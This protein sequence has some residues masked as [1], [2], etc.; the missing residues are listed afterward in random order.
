MVAASSSSPEVTQAWLT[1]I[2]AAFPGMDILCDDLA[3]G[4][5]CHIGPGG[6]GIGVSCRPDR[7]VVSGLKEQAASQKKILTA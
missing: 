3:M 1:E 2:R 4:V 5:S 7:S 6:L